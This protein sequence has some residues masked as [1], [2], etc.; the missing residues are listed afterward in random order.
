M[1]IFEIFLKYRRF[2]SVQQKQFLDALMLK[3]QTFQKV[4]NFKQQ[5]VFTC[6]DESISDA[7]NQTSP[8]AS[9]ERRVARVIEKRQR[10]E[11]ACAN[12]HL[13]AN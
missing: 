13:C 2:L 1:N 10:R 12:R 11:H 5:Q 4:T 3:V 6:F 7:K 9:H 8:V